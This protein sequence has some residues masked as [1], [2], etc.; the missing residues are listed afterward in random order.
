MPI[1]V[2]IYAAQGVAIADV[3]RA[4][5]LREIVESGQDLLLEHVTWHPLDG[6]PAKPVA[7]LRFAPDDIHVAATDA[8]ED[9][10]VHAQWHDVAVDLGPYRVTGQMPTMPGFDPGRAL[11]RPTGEFVLLRDVQVTLVGREEAGAVHQ[12][13]A[14]VNRYVVDR[15]E[16][17]LMLGFFFPGAEMVLTGGHEQVAAGAGPVPVASAEPTTAPP[18]PAVNGVAD[19]VGLESSPATA[20]PRVA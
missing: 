13:S 3:A 8:F 16:A 2:E 18:A 11:A 19:A 1:R 5:S 17:D 12:R 14:L 10:P 6:G 15:V 7:D 20:A 9:G 4:G